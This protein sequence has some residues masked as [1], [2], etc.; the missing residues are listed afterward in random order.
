MTSGAEIPYTHDLAYLVNRLAEAPVQPPAS[1]KSA[2]WLTPWA[3]AAR[4]A[5][6]DTTLDRS[7]ASIAAIDAIDWA[8]AIVSD[9]SGSCSGAQGDSLKS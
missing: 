3:V 8:S 9:G 1:V 7:S 4:Y 6:V 2:D 5:T